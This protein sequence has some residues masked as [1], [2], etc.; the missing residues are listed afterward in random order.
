MLSLVI[1]ARGR[2]AAASG[3]AAALASRA[4]NLLFAD[5]ETGWVRLPDRGLAP[6][7]EQSAFWRSG[8]PDHAAGVPREETLS[9]LSST[10]KRTCLWPSP[11]AA[12]WHSV[13]RWMRGVAVRLRGA[14]GGDEKRRARAKRRRRG[15]RRGLQPLLLSPPCTRFSVR[16]LTGALGLENLLADGEVAGRGV[17]ERGH[18]SSLLWRLECFASEGGCATLGCVY[19]SRRVCV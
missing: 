15:R 7:A 13:C 11:L 5:R 14:G 8:A 19:A 16:K 3:A 1:V 4:P 10:R 18:L 9:L 6:G 17:R 12:V 2:A